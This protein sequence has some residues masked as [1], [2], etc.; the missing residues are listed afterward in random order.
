MSEL[1]INSADA[2]C[3]YKQTQR[4]YLLINC[5]D[6]EFITSQNQQNAVFFLFYFKKYQRGKKVKG[7]IGLHGLLPVDWSNQIFI[8][9]DSLCGIFI[10]HKQTF[11][12]YVIR[13]S[14]LVWNN[15]LERLSHQLLIKHCLL[16]KPLH[17][18]KSLNL[19]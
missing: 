18:V 19:V 14:L 10:Q 12:C 3:L 8:E 15:H 4:I 5:H 17:L 16:L 11:Y 13:K 6:Q 7:K 9:F 2:L 1:E